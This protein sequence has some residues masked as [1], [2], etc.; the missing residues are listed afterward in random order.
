MILRDRW[1]PGPEPAAGEVLVSATRFVYRSPWD[2]RAV[3]REARRLRRGWDERPGAVGLITGADP[4]RAT[5][6]SLSVW[7]SPEALQAF[8]CSPEHQRLVREYRPRLEDVRSVVWRPGA[9]EP[10]AAWRE[11]L[12]RLEAV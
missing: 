2:L 11:G 10:R 4:L 9:F 1:R 3:G 8:L 6:F 5:T 7:T 12:R